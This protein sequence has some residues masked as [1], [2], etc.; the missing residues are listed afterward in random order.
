[1]NLLQKITSWKIRRKIFKENKKHFRLSRTIINLAIETLVAPKGR[2]YAVDRSDNFSLILSTTIVKNIRRLNSIHAICEAGNGT[3]ALPLLRVMFEDLVDMKYISQDKKRVFDYQIYGLKSELLNLTSIEKIKDNKKIISKQI[4]VLKKVINDFCTQKKI[5]PSKNMRHFSGKKRISVC[6]EV[7]LGEMY[8]TYYS[9]WSRYI[10]ST[11][12]GN[13]DYL[14]GLTERLE[15]V[16]L[17]GGS[18]QYIKS[19]L[20]MSSGYMIDLLVLMDKH[21]G[22]AVGEDLYILKKVWHLYLN[23]DHNTVAFN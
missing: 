13:Q 15:T 16:F 1:M 6:E 22:N 19:I 12:S 20:H 4:D 18:G 7:G 11:P 10:H 8:R 23:E 5:K 17:L 21:C 9:F 2:G 14:L 3:D